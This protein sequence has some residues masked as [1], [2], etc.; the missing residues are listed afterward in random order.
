[1]DGKKNGF[2]LL[3]ER[4]SPSVSALAVFECFESWDWLYTSKVVPEGLYFVAGV[5]TGNRKSFTA[6]IHPNIFVQGYRPHSS[7]EAFSSVRRRYGR[8]FVG[9]PK[10]EKCTY[11][12]DVYLAEGNLYHS[13]GKAGFE[14]VLA[15]GEWLKREN[16]EN[17]FSNICERYSLSVLSK[18]KRFWMT[19]DQSYGYFLKG[20]KYPVLSLLVGAAE[21]MVGVKK[22]VLALDLNSGVPGLLKGYNPDWF[23]KMPKENGAV[24]DDHFIV[25]GDDLVLVR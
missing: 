3:G 10:P 24:I 12:D 1:M 17:L 20:R 13:F 16:V 5:L 14:L 23:E 2:P 21:P 18:C 22:M 8:L 9:V 25:D 19:P 6:D 15:N 7:D 4:R 11:D